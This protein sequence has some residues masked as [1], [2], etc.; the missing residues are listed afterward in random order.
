M[1]KQLSITLA[2]ALSALF[3]TSATAQTTWYVDDDAPSDPGP[4]NPFVS[5]PNE[6]GTPV[7]PFDTIQEGIDAA[8]GGDFV[9]VLSGTYYELGTLD[10][11]GKQITVKSSEGPSATTIDGSALLA[12]VVRAEN[13]ETAATVLAGFTI[14]GGNPGTDVGDDG[15][16]MRI[17]ASSPT[18]RNCVFRDN[19]ARIGGGVFTQD[20]NT[21]FRKCVFLNNDAA[22]QGGGLYTDRGQVTLDKCRFEGNYSGVGGGGLIRRT[23]AA[24]MLTVRDC[25]FLANTTDG[26]GAGLSKW[27]TGGLVVERTHFV[28]NSASNAGGGAFINGGGVVRDSVF[29]ANTSGSE[30][31]GLAAWSFGL[32]VLSGSTFVDNVGY[33]LWTGSSG[34]I[35]ATSLI[36]WNSAP[37]EI[38]GSSILVSYS[39]VLGGYAGTNIDVLPLFVNPAGPDGML[40]TLDDDLRLRS[41]SP[42]ID[43]GDTSIVAGQSSAGFPTDVLGHPRSVNDPN[44]PGTGIALLGTM[45]DQ[46]AYEFQ[47]NPCAIATQRFP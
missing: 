2:C 27:D 12:S 25:T 20:S 37:A 13:G 30:G 1:Q 18:I 33:G 19:V 42:C 9:Q 43:A 47:P 21:A 32:V 31:G 5:D 22:W 46:G 41:D 16:G 10:L 35:H 23:D 28:G 26:I 29:N 39:D 44:T 17:V 14:L 45:V 24:G 8:M 40:G 36:L 7:H 38:A 11:L 15:G 6:D 3:A 4:G 34:S